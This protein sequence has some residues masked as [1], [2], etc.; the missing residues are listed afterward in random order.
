[1]KQFHLN[2][3]LKDK[4]LKIVNRDGLPV[5]IACYDRKGTDFPIIY[6]V[7]RGH[8]EYYGI[9]NE[10]GLAFMSGDILLWFAD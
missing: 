9:C 3:W 6:L 2:E 8:A 1:M 5:R 4:S 10:D 7:D